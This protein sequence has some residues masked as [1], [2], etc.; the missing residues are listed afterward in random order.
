ME[1]IVNFTEPKNIK[2]DYCNA[3]LN[4]AQGLKISNTLRRSSIS[5]KVSF[6]DEP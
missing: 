5:L 6:A 1:L 3:D 2:Q 4:S